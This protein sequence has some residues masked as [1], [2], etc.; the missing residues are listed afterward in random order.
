M[1]SLAV[2]S[3]LALALVLTPLLAP[4]PAPAAA[5]PEGSPHLRRPRHPRPRWLE[6]NDTEVVKDR[7]GASESAGAT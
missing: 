2:R 5:A 4:G 1:R 7:S 6:P 3:A